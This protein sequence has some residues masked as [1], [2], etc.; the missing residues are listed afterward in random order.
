MP[1]KSVLPSSARYKGS[2]CC[3]SEHSVVQ[4]QVPLDRITMEELCPQTALM[5][6][7]DKERTRWCQQSHVFHH[8]P[9][10][11]FTKKWSCPTNQ[12]E[13]VLLAARASSTILSASFWEVNTYPFDNYSFLEP[14]IQVLVISASYS[15]TRTLIWCSSQSLQAPSCNEIFL[16]SWMEVLTEVL[17]QAWHLE[18]RYS[19]PRDDWDA[20]HRAWSVGAAATLWWRWMLCRQKL[21]VNSVSNKVSTLWWV[22]FWILHHSSHT[23]A[24][25]WSSD[26]RLSCGPHTPLARIYQL[27]IV[28]NSSLW[29]C[30]GLRKISQESWLLAIW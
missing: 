21:Q 30:A 9:Y 4:V 22:K 15:F 19:W 6:M 11:L 29:Q 14:G 7:G 5:H 27:T 23:K 13:P 2:V 18:D 8:D 3:A 10:P 20:G 25:N 24:R 26:L 1:I 17:G 28:R 16:I 12:G